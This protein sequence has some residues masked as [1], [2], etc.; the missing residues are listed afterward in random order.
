MQSLYEWDFREGIDID[1][2]IKRNVE[3]FKDDCDK[4]FIVKNIK[5]IV[6]YIKEI[7]KN[8]AECAPEWPIEQIAV[9]DKTILRL[10]VYEMLYNKD[11]PPKVVINE[12]VELAKTYGGENSSKFING[13]LGTLFKSDERYQQE[14]G[15]DISLLEL[16][17]KGKEDGK[18]E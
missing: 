8:I 7:D 15:E 1:K 14:G 5:G 4:E 9:I 16:Y 12:A 11:I 10:A 6:K 13:V 3:N 2:I 17:K 18:K